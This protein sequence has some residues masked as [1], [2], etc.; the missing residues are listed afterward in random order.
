MTQTEYDIEKSILSTVLFSHHQF[1]DEEFFSNVELYEEHFQ[2]NFHKLVVKQINHNKAKGLSIQED[3]IT[4]AMGVNGTLT[5]QMIEIMNTNPF[6]RPLFE[7]YYKALNKP[8]L[9]NHWDI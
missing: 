8:K 7:E 6:G 5:S 3:Y 9:S 2:D 4:E 1:K